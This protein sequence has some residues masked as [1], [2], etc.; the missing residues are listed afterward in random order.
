MLIILIIAG[1]FFLFKDSNNENVGINVHYYQ[2]GVEVFP[3]KGTMQ[4]LI[5][6]PGGSYNQISFD[7]I[8]TNTGGV[9][10]IDM[11][12]IDASPIPFKDALPIII[13]TLSVEESKTLWSSEIINTPQFESY[14]QPVKFWLNVS[15]KDEQSGEINYNEHSISLTFN[16]IDELEYTG[17]HWGITP[18]EIDN[19]YSITTNGTNIW[20]AD[21]MGSQVYKYTIDG[22]Y[23]GENWSTYQIEDALVYPYGMTTDSTYIWIVTPTLDDVCKFTMNGTLLD[24]W[25]IYHLFN[26]KDP[27]G[28][29]TDGNYIWVLGSYDDEIYKFTMGMSYTGTHWN[30]GSLGSTDSYSIT[31]D[32]IHIFS[33]D[34]IDNVVYKFNMNGDFISCKDI[35]SAGVENAVGITTYGTNILIVDYTDMEVYKFLK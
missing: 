14:P 25:D 35:S 3:N 8:G 12:I 19:P 34:T 9:P 10:I 17:E 13:Q 16:Q 22:V 28:I 4:S 33:V 24:C 7:I 32:G 15:G 5:T 31:T 21:L 30:I 27:V 20:I 1:S 26:I 6:P 23:T 18:S 29:T 11:K 2:D